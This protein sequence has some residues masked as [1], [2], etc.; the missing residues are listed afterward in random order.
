MGVYLQEFLW[1]Q[2]VSFCSAVKST[3]YKN[4]KAVYVELNVH[5]AQSFLCHINFVQRKGTTAKSKQTPTDLKEK[6]TTFLNDV[7]TVVQME[8]IPAE[9]IMDWDQTG[10]RL[11]PSSNWTMEK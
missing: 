8:E 6:K 5:W 4:L 7:V 1:L 2:H 11:V 10:I 9:L 3:N